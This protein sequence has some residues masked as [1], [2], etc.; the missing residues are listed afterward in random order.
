MGGDARIRLISNDG[1]EMARKAVKTAEER[2]GGG[3]ED[4]ESGRSRRL[5]EAAAIEARGPGTI[6]EGIT[7]FD[8]GQEVRGLYKHFWRKRWNITEVRR[9]LFDG[10]QQVLLRASEDC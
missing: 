10:F 8:L 6:M 2:H 1:L 5:G 4:G 3:L 9:S 7:T